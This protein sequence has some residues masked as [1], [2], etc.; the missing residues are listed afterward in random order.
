MGQMNSRNAAKHRIYVTNDVLRR[1]K[2]VGA[3]KGV[4]KCVENIAGEERYGV[5]EEV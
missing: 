4:I 5:L 1:R 3:T 2:G